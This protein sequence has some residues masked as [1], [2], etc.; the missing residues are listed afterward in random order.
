MNLIVQ[1][2]T[3]GLLGGVLDTGTENEKC[4]IGRY[5]F[6]LLGAPGST[7]GTH[8]DAETEKRVVVVDST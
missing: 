8:G 7:G 5:A 3:L 1:G 2:N 6:V 4:E